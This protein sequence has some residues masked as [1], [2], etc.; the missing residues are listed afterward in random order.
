MA[1]ITLTWD[2]S[3]FEEDVHKG[4]FRLLQGPGMAQR[5]RLALQQFQM[6]QELKRDFFLAPAAL[7]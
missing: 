2:S 7:S 1:H 6:M 5:A 4:L 3:S